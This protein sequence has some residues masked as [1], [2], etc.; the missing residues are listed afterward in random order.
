MGAGA[1]LLAGFVNAIAGGGTLLTFPAL[2]AAGLSPL[3]ANA[4][5]TVA[6]LPGALSSMLGYRAELTGV[7]RWATLFAVPSLIGGTVGALLLLHTPSDDF[8]HLVPWLVLG[9]TALF[10]AQRPLLRLVRGTRVS[11][12]DAAL[13]SS[14]PSAGLLGAQFFVGVYG[15]YFGAGIGILMLAALGLMGFTNIHRMNGLKNWGGFC[16]NL[17]AALTFA[18]SDIVRWPVVLAMALG[19]MTG[20]YVGARAAQRVPQEVVR[21]AVAAVGVLSGLWLLVRMYAGS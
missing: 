8:D 16:M 21:R 6:L 19:S 2:V 7:R 17:V 11:V 9:A 5:S 1:A 12:S 15:G 14:T 3:V 18:A 20:G 10:L 4:T 13:A